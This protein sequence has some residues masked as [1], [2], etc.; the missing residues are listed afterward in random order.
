[1]NQKKME[2]SNEIEPELVIKIFKK[3]SDEDVNFM[4]FSPIWSRPEWMICQTS[5]TTTS[6]SSVCKT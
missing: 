3:I 2:T 1:M 5:G 4:G 6:G